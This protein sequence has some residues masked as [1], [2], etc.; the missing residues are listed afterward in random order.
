M[1]LLAR[2]S[3]LLE[4]SWQDAR[5]GARILWQAPAFS[6]TI[7]LLIA[8]VVG[9]NAS[10]FSIVHGL[11]GKPA[12]GVSATAL[13][14]LGATQRGRIV[15]PE[16]SYA[17][18]Q[19]YAA[20]TRTLQSLAAFG[21]ER[22]TIGL[23]GGTYAVAGAVVSPN[24]FDVLGV[25]VPRGRAFSVHAQ[26]GSPLEV[27]VS[28]HFWREQLDARDDAIG[29]AVQLGGSPAEIVGVAP[30]QFRGVSFTE[31]DDV[32]VSLPVYATAA[33]KPEL[34]NDRSSRRV[35]MIGRLV[36][37]ATASEAQAEL[38]TIARGLQQAYPDTNQDLSLVAVPYTA[39]ALGPLAQQGSI[40]FAILTI[41]S[42]IALAVVCL[43]AANLMLARAVARQRDIAVRQSLGASRSRIFRQ[44]LAE[45]VV[46]SLAGAAGAVLVV[47]WLPQTLMSLLPPNRAGVT[48]VPDVSADPQVLAYAG[49]L[50]LLAAL[51]FTALPAFRLRRSEPAQALR[52]GARTL[53]AG[54]SGTSRFLVVVQV[55]LAATLVTSAGLAYRS[56][57]LADTVDLRFDKHS[58]L[59][60]TVRNDGSAT[61]PDEQR[62]LL[63]RFLERAQAIPGVQSVSFAELAPGGV[64]PVRVRTPT[65]DE[66]LTVDSNQIGS[67]YL[68]VLGVA[69]LRGDGFRPMAAGARRTA[70]VNANLAAALW[71]GESPI[72]QILLLG[73]KREAVQVIGVAPDGILGTFRT[74]ARPKFLL[75]P[76]E[77]D[78]VVPHEITFIVRYT[79]SLDSVASAIRSAFHDANSRMP[80]VY[81]RTM[82]DQLRTLTA[83]TLLIEV[84]LSVFA[85]V[86]LLVAAIGVYAIMSFSVRS[87][88]RDFG[89]RM[90]LG[91]TS[92]QI[93]ASVLREGLVLAGI[94]LVA[95]LGLSAAAG[96]AFRALLVGVSPTDPTT[97]VGV[98]VLVGSTAIVAA[99]LPAR[100][101]VRI[102][103]VRILRQD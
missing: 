101:V 103:P 34:L 12:R 44:Q 30:P 57:A 54:R 78:P 51:A 82:E 16:D 80:I 49:G 17:D 79:T 43:N 8:L 22:M 19:D 90:A 39:T 58:L 45:A 36:A 15:T 84:V 93:L 98:F 10:A 47:V 7:A 37:G 29:R 59:L 46:I 66:P 32:W 23:G 13:V 50:S 18:Y 56:L 72:G 41:I 71:P 26:G 95:G 99:Y 28:D 14:M 9:V 83:T 89:V 33:G 42:V 96:Q 77:Q 87:R 69:P 68:R 6:A 38:Q 75:L 53:V 81:V 64:D 94:G 5:V 55:A 73:D 65:G 63:Q 11:L 4:S 1:T 86:C 76:A 67:D 102:D 20:R 3:H 31:N 21:S 24:Y 70:L 40:L 97:F 74:Q 2:L 52:A 61:T 88:S 25:R 85:V 62:V 100:R 92:G 27:V 35:L 91:A 48:L 60:V